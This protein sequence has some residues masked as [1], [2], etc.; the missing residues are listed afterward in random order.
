MQKTEV[1]HS[2]LHMETPMATEQTKYTLKLIMEIKI[3]NGATFPH[4]QVLR[5]L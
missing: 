3:L 5:L 1:S 4:Q 2:S